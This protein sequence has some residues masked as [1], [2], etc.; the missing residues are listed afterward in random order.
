MR[1]NPLLY[2]RKLLAA[3]EFDLTDLAAPVSLPAN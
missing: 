3:I 1:N 2:F